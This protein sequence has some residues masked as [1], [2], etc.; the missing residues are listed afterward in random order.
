MLSTLTGAA[1]SALTGQALGGPDEDSMEHRD[2]QGG[3]DDVAEGPEQSRPQAA[4][5]N[6]ADPGQGDADELVHEDEEAVAA[7]HGD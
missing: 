5:Q 2:P 1:P 3:A 7:R 6:A 4:W